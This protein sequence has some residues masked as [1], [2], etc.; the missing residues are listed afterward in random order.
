MMC[1][2]ENIFTVEEAQKRKPAP[3]VQTA[4]TQPTFGQRTYTETEL[5]SLLL[6]DGD[7]L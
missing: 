5:E 1:K 7:L 2:N 4:K 3:Q 6:Q